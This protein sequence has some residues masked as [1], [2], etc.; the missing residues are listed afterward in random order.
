MASARCSVLPSLSE[1]IGKEEHEVSVRRRRVRRKRAVDSAS[2]K[3]RSSRLA[4]KEDPHYIDATSKAARIKAAKL[5][6]SKASG[7]MKKALESSGVLERPPPDKITSNKLRC[8]AHVCGLAHL[9]EMGDDVN[10]A[11]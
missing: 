8:L 9:S 1:L 2:K 7:R 4:E 10:P 5:D 11:V 6:L 3:R